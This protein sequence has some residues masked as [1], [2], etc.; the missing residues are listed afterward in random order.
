[1]ARLGETFNSADVPERDDFT[2]LTPGQYVGMITASELKDTQKGGQMIVLEIDIQ[3]GEFAGRKLFERL[4]IKNEN[5]KA[6]IIAFQTLSE[7]V[8]S[9]G[10][11]TIKDTEELHNKRFLINVVVEPAKPYKDKETGEEK[12]G[13]PQN[14]IK[15]FLLYT[16]AVVTPKAQTSA[17]VKSQEAPKAAVGPW[18]K[19]TQ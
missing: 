2:P 4:N 18:K 19:R 9:V 3:D 7:V 10:K 8:K 13:S 15:K 5:P 1:M 17:T 14:R 16:G 11:T 6:E 12:P